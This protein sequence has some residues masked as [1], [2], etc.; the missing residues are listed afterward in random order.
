[1]AIASIAQVPKD[2]LD[3]GLQ[4]VREA[5]R[6]S[7]RLELIAVRPSARTREVLDEAELDLRRGVVGD[8]WARSGR[9]N[10]DLQVTLMSSRVAALVAAS[11]DHEPWAAA[12]DQL[13]VDLDLSEENLPAGARLAIGAEAVL[14]I[15]KVPHTGCGKFIKRFGVA[16]MKFVNSAEGR[17]LR[18]RGVNARVVEPGTIRTGD[19]VRKA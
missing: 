15:S 4:H 7:G 5:P 18:L 10:Q 2:V 12:G 14:E 8:R 3:R 11:D 9:R 19:P 6:D 1:M 13:Y 16:A 17:E